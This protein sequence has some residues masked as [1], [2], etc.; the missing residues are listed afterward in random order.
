MYCH[1]QGLGAD[2]QS[3]RDRNRISGDD[4]CELR[5]ARRKKDLEI[6]IRVQE[7]IRRLEITMKNIGRVEGFEGTKR[8]G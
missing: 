3:E 5:Q 7:K 1:W 2:A 8:L 4:E 6:A